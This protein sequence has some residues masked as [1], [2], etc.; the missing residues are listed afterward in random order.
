MKKSLLA[1]AMLTLGS[2]AWNIPP[3]DDTIYVKRQEYNVFTVDK[4]DNCPEVQMIYWNNCSC[5]GVP[6]RKVFGW[7]NYR[8]DLLP[9]EENGKFVA[10]FM[11][12]DDEGRRKRMRIVSDEFS[13]RRTWYDPLYAEDAIRG[14]T[15]HPEKWKNF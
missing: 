2:V 5:N 9:R 11:N 6:H 7:G 8:K 3:R 14:E 15:H 1:L 4:D 12:V 10:E 13:M